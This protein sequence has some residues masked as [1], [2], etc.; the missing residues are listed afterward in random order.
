MSTPLEAADGNKTNQDSDPFSSALAEI[1]SQATSGFTLNESDYRLIRRQGN[2]FLVPASIRS[3]A[4][5]NLP[6]FSDQGTVRRVR[7]GDKVL[8][9]RIES[10]AKS[11]IFPY[12]GLN[13]GDIIRS[14]NGYPVKSESDALSLVSRLS[15]SDQVHIDIERG[16]N[17]TPQRLY[18]RL[19]S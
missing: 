19:L 12:L 15:N 11:G 4:L 16:P 17:R 13:T 7:S 3:K 5:L 14:V 1:F 2:V 9:F 18:Y 6:A 10:L 8:G